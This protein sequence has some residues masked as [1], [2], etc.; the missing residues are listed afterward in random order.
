MA[1]VMTGKAME[2]SCPCYE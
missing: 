1:A 2:D